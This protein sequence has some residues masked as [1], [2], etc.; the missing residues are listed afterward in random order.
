MPTT[1]LQLRI[2][3]KTLQTRPLPLWE[4]ILAEERG[5]KE[6]LQRQ[7]W[8]VDSEQEELNSDRPFVV[9]SKKAGCVQSLVGVGQVSSG[10]LT[11]GVC[12]LG[13][14]KQG[15]AECWGWEGCWDLRIEA[16][17]VKSFIYL[18]QEYYVT[19]AYKL[20]IKQILFCHSLFRFL[21]KWLQR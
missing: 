21:L 20:Q 9:L 2:H 15:R 4:Y 3:Q 5:S 13:S 11:P 18:V 16:E 7:P 10:G 1:D 14:R 6:L 12:S 8:L 17:G 19:D